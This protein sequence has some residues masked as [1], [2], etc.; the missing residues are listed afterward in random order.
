MPTAKPSAAPAGPL[1]LRLASVTPQT[2]DSKTLRFAVAD[3]RRLHARPGQF[4][5]FS[6]LFD[7]KKVSRSYSIC[8]S[9]AAS[10]YVDITVKRVEQGCASVYLND[11]AP[12]GMTVEANGPFGHFCFDEHTHRQIVLIAAGSGITPMM[13][14]LRY[15]DDVCLD[16]AVTLLYCVRTNR[17]VI[18]GRELEELRA[19]RSRFRYELLL[20]QPPPDWTGARGH[21]NADFVRSAVADLTAPQFF[22]CGPPPFM[23]A[24]RRMLLDLGVGPER[25]QQE[26]F[27]GSKSKNQPSSAPSSGQG[28][29]SVA[30]ARSQK[31]AT[32]RD[33]RT[34]LETA[35][36]H[37]VTIPSFCRQG[38]CGTCRTKLL[39]GR[40][41]MDAEQGL[42]AESKAQ[43][44]VLTCVGHAD[45]DVT[46]DA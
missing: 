9:A 17:D 29:A 24:S 42:D 40:V 3:G 5:T 36:E 4:M 23:D 15:I 21:I 39:A 38:Q 6:F 41:T 2:H 28:T 11:R 43:G 37:A 16:T 20:S 12:V 18:F 32:A 19:R 33:G 27:G 1:I 14:M 35:E 26:S 30:F 25:I 22:L 46:L 45:G 31:T 7:G 34:L 44:F 13:A 8:S 10:G